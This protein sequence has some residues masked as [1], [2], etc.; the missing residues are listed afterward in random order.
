MSSGGTGESSIDSGVHVFIHRSCSMIEAAAA[1]GAG[2]D[3]IDGGV[4]ITG[5][6]ASG[7]KMTGC[8]VEVLLGDGAGGA[9]ESLGRKSP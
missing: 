4:G 9:G 6:G 7:T 8:L 1:F 5:L 2:G 3:V